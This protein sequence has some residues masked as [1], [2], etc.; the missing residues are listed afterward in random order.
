MNK[1]SAILL[2]FILLPALAMSAQSVIPLPD[3]CPRIY[4]TG[5][6]LGWAAAML[7]HARDAGG[8]IPAEGDI[9][10]CLQSAGQSAQAAYQACSSGVP[11]WPD[12][13]QRQLWINGWVGELR[14]PGN[15]TKQRWMRWEL[16]ASAVA[17]AYGQWADVLSWEKV[18]GKMRK[19][20]TCATC[21]FQLGFDLAYATQ[22]Y[23][24]AIEANASRDLPTSK[25]LQ[26]TLRELNR[27]R[28][29]LKKALAVLNAYR[30]V[31]GRNADAPGCPGFG[32]SELE[33]R[34]RAITLTAPSIT[35]AQE[36]L[37]YV[38]FSSDNVGR[39]LA[40]NCTAGAA[41]AAPAAVGPALPPS[42]NQGELAGDWVV[43]F[44]SWG[45]FIGP[46]WESRWA[47]KAKEH[48]PQALVIRFTRDGDEY[49]GTILRPPATTSWIHPFDAF[50][51]RIHL[52]R[53]GLRLLR[54]R[55][56]GANLY[57]G[58]HQLLG[59]PSDVTD[60]DRAWGFY[61]KNC[62]I[63]VFGN[64]AKL[65]SPSYPDQPQILQRGHNAGFLLLHQ[66]YRE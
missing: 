63:V 26:I 13:K 51:N 37:R 36:E 66:E 48:H 14:H 23:R 16:V 5:R 43:H 6:W 12:W 34:L 22:A 38:S 19:R 64:A 54:M 50:G 1:R 28:L 56:I 39:L 18:D 4:D 29:R 11:A 47:A 24:L 2:A 44:L 31:K 10:R 42:S 55:K 60:P 3:C 59:I 57:R 65:I 32:E 17:T 46:E 20:T 45:H 35:R 30:A 62:D 7:E 41:Q 49:A 21:F 9:I 15:S 52:Y 61:H 33:R 25:R 53:Q 8:P 40:Q 58:T 27:T